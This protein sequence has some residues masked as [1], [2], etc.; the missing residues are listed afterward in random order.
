MIIHLLIIVNATKT[1]DC[2]FDMT[3][4]TKVKIVSL[5]GNIGS[6]KSTLLAKLQ[7]R[8]NGDS[9]VIFLQEP[10]D[11][12]ESIQDKDGNTMIQKF[13]ADQ[14]KYSFSFQMMAYISRLALIKKTVKEN[15]GAIIITE[16]SLNTDKYVF[17][18]MLYSD[19]MIEDVN[20][21]IYLKWFETFV[22]DFPIIGMIY[23]RTDPE[24]CHRRIK[25]RSRD[26]E[27]VI[28]IEYLQKCSYYHNKMMFEETN[29]VVLNLDGNE[30]IKYKCSEWLDKIEDYLNSII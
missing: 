14:Q 28:A 2:I 1:K 10:V 13:Y 19:G 22:E 27:D 24:V 8:F 21:T 23:L 4:P 25:Q 12:W 20:Y 3:T 30:D 6:G 29:K 15:P 9:R 17:A 7:E 26:G 5:E 11:V 18:K 16:R